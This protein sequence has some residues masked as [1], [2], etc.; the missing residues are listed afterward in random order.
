MGELQRIAIGLEYLGTRYCG[1]QRQPALPSLQGVVEAALAKIAGAPVAVTAAGRTD[2]GVHA[3]VQVVHADVPGSRPLSAWVRGVNSHLPADVCINWAIPVDATFHARFAAT[4]R[5]YRYLLLNRATRPGLAAG[6]VGW[7]HRPLDLAA[8]QTAA[9]QL[10]GRHD[11]S[12]FRAAECQARTPVRNLV[13]LDVQRFGECFVFDLEADAFLHHMVRN[14]V[15]SLVAVGNGTRTPEWI[16]QVLAARDR[17][18]AAPT[19]SPAGLYLCGVAY[20][21][22]WRLPSLPE[23]L[24]YP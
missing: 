7:H 18:Q 23:R 5:R 17:A 3:S 13:R 9:V 4:A 22:R 6:R 19:F 21:P 16:A 2:A 11:F 8:M 10:V 24:P 14:I 20:D 15:G 1:W 12:S